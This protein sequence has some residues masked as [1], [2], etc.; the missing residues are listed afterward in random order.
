MDETTVTD[1]DATA[2]PW[3]ETYEAGPAGAELR[4][5]AGCAAWWQSPR[6]EAEDRRGF[7]D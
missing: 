6:V 2:E 1:V 4:I 7:G 5:A 3:L